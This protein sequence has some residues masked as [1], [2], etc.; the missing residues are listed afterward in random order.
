MVGLILVERS[1]KMYVQRDTTGKIISIFAVA[2]PGV[3]EEFLDDNHPD[4]LEFHSNNPIKTF[5]SL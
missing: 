3:A 4:L 1:Y 2:Q 5:N